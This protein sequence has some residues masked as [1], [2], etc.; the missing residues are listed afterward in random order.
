MKEIKKRFK[1]DLYNCVVTVIVTDDMQASIKSFNIDYDDAYDCRGLYT[2]KHGNPTE[3]YIFINSVSYDISTPCHEAFHATCNI[4]SY[5][6]CE[7]D[8]SS[9]EAY[10]Y[11]LGHITKKTMET[12]RLFENKFA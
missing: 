11:L 12:I 3:N 6:G 5:I 1:I 8:D 10:A 2:Y 4:L 7:L 9:E